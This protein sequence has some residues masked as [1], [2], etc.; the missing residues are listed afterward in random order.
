MNQIEIEQAVLGAVI[1]DK[2]SHAEF[3]TL[4]NSSEVFT[5]DKHRI[6]C[7][8]IKALYDEN[9]PIDI[10]TIAEWAKKK[11]LYK[12]MGGPKTLSQIATK[13]S[14]AAHFSIHIRILL[15]SYLKRGVGKFAQKLLS[16]SVNE[17]DDIF[18]TV[19]KVQTGL[20]NL[21]NQ[22]IVKDEKPI[23]ETLNEIRAKW[24]IENISGLAGIPT[25]ITALDNATG[26][27][28]DSDLIV[29]GARPGQGKTAL[30]MSLIQSYCKRDIPVG[31]F[32]LEMGQVQLVQR[33]LSLESNVFA[34]KIRND[35][36]EHYDRQ[37]LYEAYTTISKWPIHINDEA[38]MTLRKLR[39]KAHRWKKEYG[40]KLLCVDYLQL[41]SSDTKK[42]NRESEISE[43]SRGLKILAKDLNI[44]VIA[45][46]Q[47]S[48]AVESRP[49]KMPQLSDLRESGAIEQD[50]DMIWFLMRP[51][52]YSQFRDSKTTEV[53]N[54][55]YDTENLCI[56]SIAKFRAG[57]TKPIALKFDGN[58]MKFSDYGTT[59]F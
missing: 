58:L 9:K 59:T 32:S 12:N 35:K 22:V 43:I 47:L 13:I 26:G 3:F 31:M 38:G 16:S 30:I 19:T 53:E 57:E 15:E 42:F 28:V 14:S 36:Y 20:D 52:Y 33:L 7:N 21:V 11:G 41:M 5:E 6:V 44:P 54:V 18:E 4:V 50:A 46:S 23:T 27:L 55:Q 29:V 1:I 45:L 40:I 8:A 34:Y 49:D 25:G 48:R 10:V 2:D 39:I 56:L 17:V 24:E 51:G 37:R